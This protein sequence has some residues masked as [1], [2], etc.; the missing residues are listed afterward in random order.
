MFFKHS[1]REPQSSVSHIIISDKLRKS[2]SPHNVHHIIREHE[3]ARL[4]TKLPWIAITLDLGI[5]DTQF[6]SSFPTGPTKIRNRCLRIW[7]AG[8]NSETFPFLAAMGLEQVMKKLTARE[9]QPLFF[10]PLR[11]QLHDR[12][13]FGSTTA[14]EHMKWEAGQ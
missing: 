4:S 6:S 11:Q 2:S 3:S 12:I 7:A 5:S 14:D 8:M 9:K 1:A 13:K 10:N